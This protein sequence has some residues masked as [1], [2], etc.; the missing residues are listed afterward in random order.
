MDDPNSDLATKVEEV[1]GGYEEG[2]KG[3]LAKLKR[4]LLTWVVGALLAMMAVATILLVIESHRLPKEM[5][6]K[7]TKPVP[8][9]ILPAP[10]K[11]T[12]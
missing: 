6:K 8:V 3:R 5:P 1:I 12:P 9:R 4:V 2:P 10:G 11:A 7:E